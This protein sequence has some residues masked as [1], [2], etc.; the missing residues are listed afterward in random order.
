MLR[1]A[2]HEDLVISE[3]E[4]TAPVVLFS[5]R[6]GVS[7]TRPIGGGELSVIGGGVLL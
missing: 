7:L 4:E 2:A 5:V 3:D 1:G 6:R